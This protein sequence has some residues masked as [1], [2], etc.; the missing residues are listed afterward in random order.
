MNI[1]TVDFETYYSQ[2]YSLSKM[3]TDAYV[4]DPRFQVIGVGIKQND[5]ATQWFTGSFEAVDEWLAQWPWESSM[6]VCHNTLFD[7]FILTQRFG[8]KPKLWADTLAMGRALVPFLKYHSLAK[9]AEALGLGEKGTEVHNVIGM[10]REDFTPEGMQKYANYCVNDVELTYAIYRELVEFF[11]PI[12]MKLVDMSIRMF[13][14]PMLVGDTEGLKKQYDAELQR[15]AQLLI[16]SG[17]T[18]DVLMS[19]DKFAAALEDLGVVPPVKISART[20]KEAWAFAKS[21]KE[22]VALLE[23]DNPD[24]QTLVAARLGLKTTIAETRTKRMIET[25]MRKCRIGP[26]VGMTKAGRSARRVLATGADYK[27]PGN[28]LPVYLNFWGAKTTGRYSGGNQINWQN[29]PARGPSAGIRNCI[30]APPGYSLVV[31]DSSNIELRVAMAAAGQDDVVDKLSQGVDL[32][33]DFASKIYGR[34]ITKADKLER[35]LGKV[36]M[37]SLQYGAGWAKFKEMVRVQ[38]GITL[39]EDEAKQIVNTYRRVHYK[40]VDLWNRCNTVILRDILN[41]N[42]PDAGLKPVDVNAWA[43]TNPTGFATPGHPGVVYYDLKYTGNEWSYDSGRER[44]KLYG[45]KVVENL[46]QY[47]ARNIVMWQTARCN[48]RY[49]VVLSVHDEMVCVVPDD[50]V[51][52]C[53]DFMMECLMKAPP[54]C[55][56]QIPLAGEVGHGKS[57]GEAK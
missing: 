20:G 57:Y 38:T 42:L 46:C 55:K 19:N 50:E 18:K 24:V 25:S 7:G 1:L 37:L 32:Y 45:G 35:M 28:A 9:L 6:V 34:P 40:I 15:K 30:M 27:M 22:F 4:L 11:P 49:Q 12:E 33:C 39:T 8:I 10:R 44:V 3:Q 14:E 36:A 52:A 17:V 26:E 31:G 54:W 48:S 47:L 56:G 43:I 2:D 53:E 5:T 21:D 29:L 16:A 51:Q 13:T 23:D 41:G